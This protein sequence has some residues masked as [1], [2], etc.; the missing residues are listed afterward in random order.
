MLGLFNSTQA[1]KRPV[2]VEDFL[3]DPEIKIILSFYPLLITTYFTFYC[4]FGD[5]EETNCGIFCWNFYSKN[6]KTVI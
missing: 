3:K 6:G 4:F 2:F 1:L 5:E